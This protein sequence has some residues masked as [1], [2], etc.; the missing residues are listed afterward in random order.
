MKRATICRRKA[1]FFM[2]A[3]A[4][5]TEGVWIFTEPCLKLNENCSDQEVGAA[6][7]SALGGSRTDVAHPRSW[8]GLLGPLLTLA[9]VKSWT[10]FVKNAICAEIEETDGKVAVIPTKNLGVDQGFQADPSRAITVDGEALAELGASV[11]RALHS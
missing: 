4:R 5:T 8:T 2:H 3:S 1:Q 10:T 7:C 11:R 9:G 6:V